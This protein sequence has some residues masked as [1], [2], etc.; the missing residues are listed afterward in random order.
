MAGITSNG[1]TLYWGGTS[2]TAIARLTDCDGPASSAEVIPATTMDDTTEVNLPGIPAAGSI[3]FSGNY[4][5]ALYLTL[6]TA[7][8]AKTTNTIVLIS[9]DSSK[10]SAAT[11]FISALK[12]TGSLNGAIKAEGTITLSGAMTH[13]TS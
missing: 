9:S 1:M 13:S 2:G 7:L 4:E 12:P 11:G 3:S 5:K 6:Y 10:W 8:M